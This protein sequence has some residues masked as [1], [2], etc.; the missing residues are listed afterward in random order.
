MLCLLKLIFQPLDPRGQ[1]L[2][3]KVEVKVDLTKKLILSSIIFDDLVIALPLILIYFGIFIESVLETL[4][5]T[6]TLSFEDFEFLLIV[7]NFDQCY[8]EILLNSKSIYMVT[9]LFLR[10]LSIG[11]HWTFQFRISLISTNLH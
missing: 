2:T 10:G 5:V 8:F 11:T 3:L 7:S 1:S 9:F 4:D 6:L